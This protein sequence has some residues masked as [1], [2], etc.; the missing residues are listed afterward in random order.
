ML[1]STAMKVTQ[2]KSEIKSNGLLKFQQRSPPVPNNMTPAGGAPRGHG[3]PPPAGGALSP[4][5]AL[6]IAP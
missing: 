6:P 2:S 3:G 4:T 5:R 1:G